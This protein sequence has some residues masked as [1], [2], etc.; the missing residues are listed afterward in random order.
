MSLGRAIIEVMEPGLTQGN[1]GV[2][3]GIVAVL[4]LITEKYR[5]LDRLGVYA[6]AAL[7]LLVGGLGHWTWLVIL[8]GF[9]GASHKATKW[10]FEEKA[11][12][13]LCESADGHRSWGNVVANG[14]LPGL[15][16]IIAWHLGDHENGLWVF[17]ASVGVAAADTFASEIGCLDPR[18]RMIT[19]MKKCEP[20]ING[21]FSPN[22]Q[23]AAAAGAMMIALLAFA[24]DP[25]WKIALAAAL[26]GWLGCQVDSLLGAVLENRGMMTKGTVNAAAITFGILA[27]WWYLETPHL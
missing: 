18:V 26:I 21:G 16:A 11:E 5:V 3:I 27:M 8:L 6:A 23:L 7:G 4:I 2:T 13:G 22:G 15:V 17:A 10:R 1:L 20:G 24:V 9:L 25:E 19:T 12:K 14:G